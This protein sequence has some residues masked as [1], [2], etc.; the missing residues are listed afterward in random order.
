MNALFSF[1]F[2]FFAG[3]ALSLFIANAFVLS[4]GMLQAR[5][6]L[7][8]SSTPGYGV[9]NP[10]QVQPR[11]ERLRFHCAAPSVRER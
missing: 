7:R 11:F 1:G 10:M 9:G 6:A 8:M 3:V 5:Q 2:G 4:A